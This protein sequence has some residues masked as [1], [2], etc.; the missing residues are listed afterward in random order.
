TTAPLRQLNYQ[1]PQRGQMAFTTTPPAPA[2]VL[3]V[4]VTPE[5]I[6][7]TA[8]LQLHPFA[9]YPP[10]TKR[11]GIRPVMPLPPPPLVIDTPVAPRNTDK[12][13]RLPV[14]KAEARHT[15]I[16]LEEHEI[17]PRKVPPLP[18]LKID[19]PKIPV[20][21]TAAAND[22]IPFKK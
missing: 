1:L 14:I 6:T 15:I 22:A 19:I 16:V 2:I 18:P 4:T 11:P 5:S 21:K 20:T 12:I 13:A 9:I 17:I 7:R 3:P 8:V 10:V